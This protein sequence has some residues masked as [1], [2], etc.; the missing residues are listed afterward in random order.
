MY[1]WELFSFS[2]FVPKE[3]QGHDINF[4]YA[5]LLAISVEQII[6]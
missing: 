6:D 2:T 4:N 1:S 3:T 5:D